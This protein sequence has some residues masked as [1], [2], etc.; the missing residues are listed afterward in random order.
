MYARGDN[1]YHRQVGHGGTRDQY[2]PA[3]VV[4][5]YTG[6]PG[7]DP[8]YDVSVGEI[9]NTRVLNTDED[10]LRRY[11]PRP[12]VATAVIGEQ[13]EVFVLLIS[14]LLHSYICCLYINMQ[15]SRFLFNSDRH[16]SLLVRLCTITSCVTKLWLKSSRIAQRSAHKSPPCRLSR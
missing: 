15:I 3:T 4:E 7:E 16:D 8:S 5:V 9:G 11:P 13:S 1:V 6:S 2:S 12:D 10:R 14:N